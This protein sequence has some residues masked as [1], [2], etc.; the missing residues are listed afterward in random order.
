MDFEALRSLEPLL[1]QYDG[2]ADIL[3]GSLR[4][5]FSPWINHTVPNALMI[6]TPRQ[7]F[8]LAVLKE[9]ARR[10]VKAKSVE[11]LTG[12]VVLRDVYK[13]RQGISR[14]QVLSPEI[15]YPISWITEQGDRQ[16]ALQESE[17]DEGLRALTARMKQAHPTSYTAT[18]WT[19][20]W[21]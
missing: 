12:P 1:T 14:I 9:M 17:T 15:L 13:E 4:S 6:S 10:R 16:Q 3:L 19:K 21:V 18:Y 8:W 7:Y 5:G 20:T 11:E 2:R